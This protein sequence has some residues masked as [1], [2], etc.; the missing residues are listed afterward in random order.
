MRIP[1][2]DGPILILQDTTEFS[3]KRVA[4]QKIGFTAEVGGGR[5][6]KDRRPIREMLII[7]LAGRLRN[8]GECARSG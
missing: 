8:R 1:V 3:F 7:R 6:A 2:V 4:P 5:K